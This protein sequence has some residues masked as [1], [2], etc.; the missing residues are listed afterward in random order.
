MP[1]PDFASPLHLYAEEIEPR[2]GRRLG[3]LPLAITHL[4]LINAV[5]QVIRA[6]DEADAVRGFSAREC[7]DLTTAKTS[8]GQ[9][10]R[11]HPMGPFTG[12]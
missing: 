2:T 8:A 3:N 1:L 7:S 10:V 4:A 12:A 9:E 6:E 11:L 5:V